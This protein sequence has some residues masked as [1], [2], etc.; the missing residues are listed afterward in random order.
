MFAALMSSSSMMSSSS[1]SSSN[2]YP[3]YNNNSIITRRP[4]CLTFPNCNTKAPCPICKETI[5][6]VCDSVLLPSPSISISSR[7]TKGL[8]ECWRCR[9]MRVEFETG[10]MARYVWSTL[11]KCYPLF[12]LS[13][14][15]KVESFELFVSD[16]YSFVVCLPVFSH[17]IS[18][19]LLFIWL[20]HLTFSFLSYVSYSSFF[21][22]ATAS[23]CMN[24]SIRIQKSESLSK[25]DTVSSRKSY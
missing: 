12:A 3:Q 21:E 6:T 17:S 20:F 25:C 16:K 23:Q 18:C 8:H 10:D 19:S 24:L 11:K 22:T 15:D 13:L 2:L 5:C 14:L 1:S 9:R 4:P 7:R